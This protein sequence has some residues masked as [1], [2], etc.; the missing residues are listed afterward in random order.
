MTN[1]R[2]ITW[3][4]LL[5]VIGGN[6]AV[7]Y[8]YDRDPPET[9]A[10][11]DV[12]RSQLSEAW[13]DAESIPMS[14]VAG[15]MQ[16][17]A[18]VTVQREPVVGRSEF[19]SFYTIDMESRQD[20]VAAIGELVVAMSDDDP[21]QLLS[22]MRSRNMKLDEKRLDNFIQQSDQNE[23]A[24]NRGPAEE[25]LE[26]LWRHP[27]TGSH[28]VGVVPNATYIRVWKPPSI[29]HVSIVQLGETASW[30]WGNEKLYKSVFVS[31]PS[32]KK[33]NTRETT[34]IADVRLLVEHD[35]SMENERGL[36]FIRLWKPNSQTMWQPLAIKLVRIAS[37]TAAP[38][39]IV[40]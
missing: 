6:L 27:E 29:R 14:D 12:V 21:S 11:R 19:V 17:L 10:S 32:F 38:P 22:Y 40:W 34:P 35:G 25:K 20:L 13:V 9:F 31:R 39:H 4:L 26:K 23:T 8:F 37:E 16:Q 30:V 24:G 1:R 15:A 28:W 3:V 33:A 7:W 2:L 18:E 5:L 36:Y